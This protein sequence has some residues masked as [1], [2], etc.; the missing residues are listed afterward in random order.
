MLV[1]IEE[2]E[3]AEII[4]ES[5]HTLQKLSTVIHSGFEGRAILY[6]VTLQVN[7]LKMIEGWSESKQ[8]GVPKDN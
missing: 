5:V 3:R 7:K 1:V 8:C 4:K 6:S 2:K